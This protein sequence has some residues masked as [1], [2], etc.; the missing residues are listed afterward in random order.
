MPRLNSLQWPTTFS[1]ATLC[2]ILSR[3]AADLSKPLYGFLFTYALWLATVFR[4]LCLSTYASEVRVDRPRL[5][6]MRRVPPRRASIIYSP[7]C[8]RS[9]SR[10]RWRWISR[11]WIIFEPRHWHHLW[12]RRHYKPHLPWIPWSSIGL[13]FS[14]FAASHANSVFSSTATAAS[15]ESTFLSPLPDDEDICNAIPWRTQAAPDW[16]RGTY[17]Q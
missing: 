10:W 4:H 9:P 6:A 1:R 12:H 7:N 16:Q 11:S 5:H 3:V 15:S 8:L 2:R 17:G 14:I 13:G